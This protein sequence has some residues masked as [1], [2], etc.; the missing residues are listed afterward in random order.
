MSRVDRENYLQHFLPTG[1]E[2]DVSETPDVHI[3]LSL[4]L[5]RLVSTGLDL[6]RLTR[7]CGCGQNHL[8][9]RYGLAWVLLCLHMSVTI[10]ACI[11]FSGS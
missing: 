10:A 9:Q 1:D 7:G 5:V 2:N 11:D 4:R 6:T 8:M 3:L